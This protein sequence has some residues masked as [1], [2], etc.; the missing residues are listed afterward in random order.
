MTAKIAALD[1]Q[2]VDCVRSYYQ[3]VGQPHD[4]HEYQQK[5]GTTGAEKW[6]PVIELVHAHGVDAR[7]LVYVSIG[8]SDGS[9][10]LGALEHTDFQ[11]GILIEKDASAAEAARQAAAQLRRRARK[12]LFVIQGDA[13]ESLD[14]CRATLQELRE[15]GI[16]GLVCSAQAVLHELPRRSPGYEPARF[17]GRLFS[18]SRIRFLYS[19]EPVRLSSDK[20]PDDVWLRIGT[21]DA[22][23]PQN[24]LAELGRFL[25][26]KYRLD[27]NRVNEVREDFVSLP[28]DL[29]REVIRF[30]V[31]H[32]GE[33]NFRYET[34]E[35]HGEIEPDELART[36]GGAMDGET[37]VRRTNSSRFERLYKS[38]QVTALDPKSGRPL[39][40]PARLLARCWR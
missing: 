23:L 2:L 34:F 16:D 6:R 35:F 36:I 1:K 11:Y 24:T 13:C 19:R 15:R 28:R 30:V 22:H 39:P 7:R 8:G 5:F 21:P 20:W 10:V 17:F 37:T 40:S 31:Y 9:E 4:A 25:A 33:S 29:A 14:E 3:K 12:R 26:D 32:D 18:V 27:L 38:L